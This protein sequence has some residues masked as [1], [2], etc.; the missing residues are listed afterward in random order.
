MFAR[1]TLALLLALVTLAAIAGAFLY[2]TREARAQRRQQNKGERQR[3]RKNADRILAKREES[4][5]DKL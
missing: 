3:R 5:A 1:E 2:A 4:L